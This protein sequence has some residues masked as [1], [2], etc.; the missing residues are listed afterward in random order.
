MEPQGE[1]SPREVK[2]EWLPCEGRGRPSYMEMVPLPSITENAVLDV[3]VPLPDSHCCL[4][5][6]EEER[7]EGRKGKRRRGGREGGGEEG[8]EE[9]RKGGRRGG[10]EGGGEE[11]R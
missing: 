11:G 8:S 4:V 9:G 2:G 6:G 5:G 3:P 1:Q 7:E 10:R